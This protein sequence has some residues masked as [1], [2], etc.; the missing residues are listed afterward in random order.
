M[1]CWI[2]AFVIHIIMYSFPIHLI[3]KCCESGQEMDY[4]LRGA[5][6][7]VA[8]SFIFSYSHKLMLMVYII[9]VVFIQETGRSSKHTIILMYD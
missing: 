2:L 1:N 7:F 6:I 5:K 4:I 9:F 8:Q 3:F